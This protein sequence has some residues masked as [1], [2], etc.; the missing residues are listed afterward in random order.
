MPT[1]RARCL[2]ARP[3]EQEAALLTCRTGCKVILKL[4]GMGNHRLTERYLQL[5]EAFST[6]RWSWSDFLLIDEI[7]DVTRRHSKPTA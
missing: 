7:T 2:Q 1:L 5:S 4:G 6:V 3:P